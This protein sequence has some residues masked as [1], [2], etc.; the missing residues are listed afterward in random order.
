MG[1]GFLSSYVDSQ[2][3]N[4]AATKKDVGALERT[5]Y[6]PLFLGGREDNGLCAQDGC[7]ATK[8]IPGSVLSD[9]D[10]NDIGV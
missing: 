1:R 3:S 5:T 4:K 7:Y 8:E 2:G 9:L 6:K 10:R